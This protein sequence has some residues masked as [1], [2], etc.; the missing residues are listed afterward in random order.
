[1]GRKVIESLSLL[2]VDVDLYD[3]L[4]FTTPE[5][6]PRLQKRPVEEVLVVVPPLPSVTTA[7]TDVP[8]QTWI[9]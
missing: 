7:V 2:P 8:A 6:P 1:L 5:Q 9:R 3:C 4:T